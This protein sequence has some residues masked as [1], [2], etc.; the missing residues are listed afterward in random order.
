[1]RKKLIFLI[2]S[3]AIF[4]LMYSYYWTHIDNPIQDNHIRQVLENELDVKLTRYNLLKIKELELTKQNINN[5]EWITHFTNLTYLNLSKNNISNIQPLNG[6]NIQS[7]DLSNNKIEDIPLISLKKLIILDLSGN[8]IKDIDHLSNL[9]SLEDLIL[10]NN[11]IDTIVTLNLPNISL[12]DVS[13]NNLT[14]IEGIG[15]MT[16]IKRLFI[17]G[18]DI[19]NI[20]SIIKLDRLVELNLSENKNIELPIPMDFLKRI[21]KL[22]YINSNIEYLFNH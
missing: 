15:Q 5:I 8:K 17:G 16:H 22:E 2:L 19:R 12:L 20:D 1:M 6:L 4:Y 9:V 13:L 11:R 7:L 21:D 18:N 10:S 3:L 14:S